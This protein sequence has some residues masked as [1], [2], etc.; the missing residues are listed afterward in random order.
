MTLN[1][2]LDTSFLLAIL[3]LHI[4]LDSELDRILDEKYEI[5]IPE[6]V[7]DE[8][9]KIAEKNDKRGRMANLALRIASAYRIIR[10]KGEADDVLINL[11]L[12]KRKVIVATSDRNLRKRLR[13]LGI[14]TIYVRQKGYLALNST[15]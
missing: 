6:A 7:L 12:S 10:E 1:V 11:A 9:K 13:R 2:L 3:E 8:L 5:M 14:P 15:I 4:N